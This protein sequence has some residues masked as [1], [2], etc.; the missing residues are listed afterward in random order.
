LSLDYHR[1]LIVYQFD[2]GYLNSEYETVCSI[3]Q[4]PASISCKLLADKKAELHRQRC[5]ESSRRSTQEIA[6][7]LLGTAPVVL[8]CDWWGISQ[9]ELLAVEKK[10][11]T[12]RNDNQ[13]VSFVDDEAHAA[14]LRNSLN[15]GLEFNYFFLQFLQNNLFSM[16]TE[17]EA[18]EIVIAV[19]NCYD[20]NVEKMHIVEEWLL[21]ERL[22]EK[23]KKIYLLVQ[24]NVLKTSRRIFPEFMKN[25]SSLLSSRLE[26]SWIHF[27][28]LHLLLTVPVVMFVGKDS[29]FEV[30]K[31]QRRKAF[32]MADYFETFVDH[33]LGDGYQHNPTYSL[34]LNEGTSLLVPSLQTIEGKK[35][36]MNENLLASMVESLVIAWIHVIESATVRRRLVFVSILILLVIMILQRRKK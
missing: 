6:G 18:I 33:A 1:H 24:E 5:D 23:K 4:F 31:E 2:I 3:F 21:R 22:T 36:E 7:L 30:V 13:F 20:Q 34:G 12:L 11:N 16:H 15:Y 17:K 9:Q 32:R 28:E 27:Y 25:Y 29:F 10:K 26:D 14:L 8:I 35:N 19:S